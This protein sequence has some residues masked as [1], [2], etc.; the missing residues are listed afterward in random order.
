MSM[1]GLEQISPLLDYKNK[2]WWQFLGIQILIFCAIQVSYSLS[3][4]YVIAQ[5]R[6]HVLSFTAAFVVTVTLTIQF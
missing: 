6:V 3:N 4:F 1:S 5:D 2:K